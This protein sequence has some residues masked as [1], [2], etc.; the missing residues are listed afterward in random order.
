MYKTADKDNLL[1]FIFKIKHCKLETAELVGRAR[2]EG[3][4]LMILIRLKSAT[5]DIHLA[6]REGIQRQ[7]GRGDDIVK[8]PSAAIICTIN[9]HQRDAPPRVEVSA[10]SVVL[11][12][13]TE[14]PPGESCISIM[15]P[16]MAISHLI[17]Y[18]AVY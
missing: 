14:P 8:V 17:I 1:E 5:E 18:D 9:D 6:A 2:D 15:M 7:P 10:T 3:D 11:S 13:D 16:Y 12:R 4:I